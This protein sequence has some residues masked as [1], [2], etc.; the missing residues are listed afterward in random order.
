MLA[1]T[2]GLAG[3]TA[4]VAGLEPAARAND[5]ACAEVIVRLPD[6]VDGEVRS[7]TDAQATGAWG[8]P[9][10]VILTCGLEPPGPSTLQCITVRGIDWLVDDGEA[11]RY[12]ITT[13]D[14]TPAVELYLDN[15]AVSPTSVLEALGTAV[16]MLPSSGSV[17][18]DRVGG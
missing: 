13:F 17:C 15:E 5:P 3:C 6:T 12:R 8:S 2:A 10:S 9:T 4:H 14:R 16:G 18:T 1:A 7:W 11:P